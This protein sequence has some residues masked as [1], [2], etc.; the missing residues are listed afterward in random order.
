[1]RTL[2]QAIAA[3]LALCLS[4]VAHAQSWKEIRAPQGGVRIEM[5]GEPTLK[6]AR[7]TIDDKPV[8]AVDANVTY[9]GFGFQFYTRQSSGSERA[10]PKGSIDAFTRHW[11]TRG[12][13]SFTDMTVG[14]YP[15]RRIRIRVAGSGDEAEFLVVVGDVMVRAMFKGKIRHPLGDRFFGSLTFDKPKQ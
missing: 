4:G 14:G 5:P 1:M 15:A 10:N 9:E 7:E 6:T 3:T 8:D 11:S 13:T 2:L 12:A